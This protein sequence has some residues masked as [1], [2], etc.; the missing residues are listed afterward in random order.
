MTCPAYLAIDLGAESGRGVLGALDE[1]TL[2]LEV[3]HRFPNVPLTLPTGLHWNVDALFEGIM[4][5]VAQA[6]RRADELDWRLASI[7]VDTWGCDFGLLDAAG[8]LLCPPYCYRDERNHAPYARARELVGDSEI[9][10]ITGIQ[11]MPFNSLYQMMAYASDQP[12][13]I[14]QA[15]RMVFMS[16]LFHHMLSGRVANEE[17]IVSTSQMTDAGSGDWARVL[18]DRLDVPSALL[19]DVVRAGTSLG[20]LKPA[21]CRQAGLQEPPE[22]VTPAG[23]DTACAVAAVPARPDSS[24]CYLSSGTWS[25]MGAELPEPCITTNP[26]FT[27]E[28]G[29]GGTTRFLKNITGLW[30]V[31][32]CRATF[33]LAGEELGYAELTEM[34]RQAPPLRTLVN[35][36][37]GPFIQPGELPEKIAAYARATGQPVPSGSGELIRCCLES[38]ALSYRRTLLDLEGLLGRRFDVLHLVGGGGRNELLNQMTADAIGRRVEVGPEEATATG[39]VLVQAMADG[40]IA[41]LDDLRRVVRQATEVRT[42]APRETRTWE[43]A[44]ARYDAL[45]I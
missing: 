15:R 10:R 24:W 16:D 32:Q 45:P 4:E 21:L 23:H 6:G 22:I 38:L 41:D 42:Y 31:Q 12:E 11:M 29:V 8:D 39:N 2:R 33:A 40:T 18:L 9:Y 13:L 44:A 37:H 30:L 28:R 25:C 14:A 35:T 7:G 1:E 19:G 20:P 27:N 34:A 36:W 26:T 3:V 5:A 43:L 17:T